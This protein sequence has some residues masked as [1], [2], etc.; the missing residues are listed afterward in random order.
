MQKQLSAGPCLCPRPPRGGP[1]DAA[2]RAAVSEASRGQQGREGPR[3][4]RG[5][6][7]AARGSASEGCRG[8]IL[9]ADVEVTQ[10]GGKNKGMMMTKRHIRAHTHVCVHTHIHA[11]LTCTRTHAHAHSHTLACVYVTVYMCVHGCMCARTHTH[12]RIHIY[13]QA[14]AHTYAPVCTRTHTH[15]RVPWQCPFPQFRGRGTLAFPR[16]RRRSPCCGAGVSRG[17]AEDSD[18]LLCWARQQRAAGG[19]GRCVEW[20]ELARR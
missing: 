2:T 15:A 10:V 3:G 14:R 20:Q 18:R 7:G 5:Q 16:G 13:T 6:A 8:G 17:T 19:G 4:G 11:R 12:T 9:R 1:D